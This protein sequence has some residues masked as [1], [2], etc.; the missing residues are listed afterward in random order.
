M[1]RCFPPCPV[2][3]STA[4]AAWPPCPRLPS[5]PTPGARASFTLRPPRVSGPTVLR[6]VAL[7]AC[8]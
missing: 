7:W 8:S 5:P 6:A 1:S 3:L 4:A 2:I